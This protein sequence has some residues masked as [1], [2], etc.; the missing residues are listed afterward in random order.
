M[1]DGAVSKDGLQGAVKPRSIERAEERSLQRGSSASIIAT[2]V[3]SPAPSTKKEMITLSNGF[4][5]EVYSDEAR[6]YAH[7]SALPDF[8]APIAN[9]YTFYGELLEKLNPSDSAQWL[10]VSLL[11]HLC[12]NAQVPRDELNRI[13]EH[14]EG[15]WNDPFVRDAIIFATDT[16]RPAARSILL[17]DSVEE[18]MFPLEKYEHCY[19]R[20]SYGGKRADVSPTD[21]HL[22][23]YNAALRKWIFHEV[24]FTTRMRFLRRMGHPPRERSGYR[25]MRLWRGRDGQI[26]GWSQLAQEI[27]LQLKSLMEQEGESRKDAVELL[28]DAIEFMEE[29]APSHSDEEPTALGLVLYSKLSSFSLQ[30]L[31]DTY[32][33]VNEYNME[34]AM[35]VL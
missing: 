16:R 19:L 7:L 8:S 15:F 3:S 34:W 11:M 9:E 5:V 28:W 4:Q 30:L 35:A 10:H 12:F 21:E 29:H 22:L 18:I 20:N 26:Q 31:L 1:G 33:L 25:S 14:V 27:L 2:A 17:G 23:A 24:P 32:L 13:V 6:G